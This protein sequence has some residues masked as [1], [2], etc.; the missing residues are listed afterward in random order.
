[1]ITNLKNLHGVFRSALLLVCIAACGFAAT[2]AWAAPQE[3][4]PPAPPAGPAPPVDNSKPSASKQTFDFVKKL[5]TAKPASFLVQGIVPGGG[6]GGG[7]HYV[8]D[9]GRDPWEKEFRATGVA[10]IR[11]FWMAE[12]QLELAHKAFSPWHSARDKF[13]THFY[14]RT[15][16]LPRM[17]FYGI[18]PNPSLSNQAFFS[19]RDTLAGVD[20]TDPL[21]SWLAV[22]GRLES[23]W[24]QAGGVS[25]PLAQSITTVFPGTPGLASQPNLIHYEVFLRPR[26]PKQPPFNIDYK[27]SY[28]FYQDHNTGQFSFRRLAF[29]LYNNIYPFKLSDGKTRNGDIFFTLHGL[30][31]ASDASAGHAVPFYLQPTLGGTDANNDPSLRGFKDYQFRGPNA[32]LMQAEYNHRLWK[33]LGAYAFYDAGKVTLIKS[34]LDFSNLRQSYGLGMSFWMNDAVLFKIYVGLGSGAGAHPYFGIP[35]FTGANLVTGRGPA[36]TPWN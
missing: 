35:D 26:Y 10:T 1:M 21:V 22:G 2:E 3:P 4:G 28:G 19:E 18:G 29:N 33:F 17:A 8:N 6:T 5:F 14:V 34:D 15:R 9:F 24:P 25:S 23:L 32:I 12:L 16:D 11:Q 20:A 30:I 31:I 27:I 7:G 36:A 13:N